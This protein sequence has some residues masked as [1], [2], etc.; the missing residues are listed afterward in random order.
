MAE[1]TMRPIIIGY[2]YHKGAFII[3]HIAGIGNPDV[4]FIS[5]TIP[6]LLIMFI[7]TKM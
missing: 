5:T 1:D 4:T 3:L 2:L 7:S 6:P